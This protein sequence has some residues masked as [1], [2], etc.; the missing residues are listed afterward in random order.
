M[1][2]HSS[3]NEFDLHENGREGGTYFRMNCFARRLVLKLRR[4]VTRKWLV[5][6]E[7]ATRANGSFRYILF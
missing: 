5:K 3:E 1:R 2:T 6:L 4:R 7:F